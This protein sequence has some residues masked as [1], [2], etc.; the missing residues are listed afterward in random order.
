ME[1]YCDIFGYRVFYDVEEEYRGEEENRSKM[2]VKRKKVVT[3]SDVCIYWSVNRGRRMAP[4]SVCRV[5]IGYSGSLCVSFHDDGDAGSF[6]HF[7]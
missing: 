7:A 1:A 3:A 5:A 2:V 6:F 4:K